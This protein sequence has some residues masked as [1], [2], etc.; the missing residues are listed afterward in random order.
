MFNQKSFSQT[1]TA[2]T[3]TQCDGVT[4]TTADV[5]DFNDNSSDMQGF[6]GDNWAKVNL[7]SNHYLSVSNAASGATYTLTT[8][9]YTT[10]S[11][12]LNL[13]FYLTGSSK[14]T[15]Y[16]LAV[17]TAAGTTTIGTITGGSNGVDDQQCLSITDWNITNQSFRFV[18]SFTLAS[19]SSGNKQIVFDDYFIH[20]V[21]EAITLPVSFSSFNAKAASAGVALTWNVG[22][23]E[24]VSSYEV[25]RSSDG[26]NFTKISSVAANGQTSYSFTD[27]KSLSVA[28]YRIKSIDANGKITYSAIV[29]LK[30]GMS[31]VL[32]KAFMSTPTTLIVQHDAAQSGSRI[33]ISSADGRLIKSQVPSM[34]SQ[35]TSVDLSSAITGLYLVRFDNGNGQTGT[36]KVMKQ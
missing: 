19:G 33:S 21:I 25:E 3:P 16:T 12:E 8:P 36:L 4:F 24:S 10:F 11:N 23:E 30:G 6:F 14:I 27:A 1:V 9:A 31:V 2:L 22:L 13:K 34:G 35:Q 17:Q 15:S 18:I 28:Y 7:G 26:K 5:V 29:S 32:L 20:G